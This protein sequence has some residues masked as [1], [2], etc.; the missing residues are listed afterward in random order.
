MQNAMGGSARCKISPAADSCQLPKLADELGKA[1]WFDRHQGR[2][3]AAGRQPPRGG[4]PSVRASPPDGGSGAQDVN[5]LI[6]FVL[7][8]L[9]LG[10]GG[11]IGDGPDQSFSQRSTLDSQHSTPCWLAHRAPPLRFQLST[12]SVSAFPFAPSTTLAVCSSSPLFYARPPAQAAKRPV[13]GPK[14][15]SR[16]SWLFVW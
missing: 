8:R 16:H 6:Q 12:F 14:S 2:A 9:H 15:E 5:Q 11:R 10:L 13:P 4:Q 3:W 1:L 7:L